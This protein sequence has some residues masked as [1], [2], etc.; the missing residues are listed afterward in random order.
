M[1]LRNEAQKR[2]SR[3]N[4]LK[5]AISELGGTVE[6]NLS[7]LEDPDINREMQPWEIKMAKVMNLD[8]F[9]TAYEAIVH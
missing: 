7:V 6:A 3:L 4:K 8:G 2:N 1:R 9:T 5:K